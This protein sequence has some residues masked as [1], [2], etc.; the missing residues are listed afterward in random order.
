MTAVL[1]DK[2]L[3]DRVI[4][5]TRRGRYPREYGY[6]WRTSV[7][8]LPRSQRLN[9][10]VYVDESTLQYLVTSKERSGINE[11]KRN[12]TRNAELI[13]YCSCIAVR[14]G[15]VITSRRSR[16]WRAGARQRI[17]SIEFRQRIIF[18]IAF[19]KTKDK[20]WKKRG[21]GKEETKDG[22]HLLVSRVILFYELYLSPF[23]L[24]SSSLFSFLSRHRG[25]TRTRNSD[26]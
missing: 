25:E 12:S 26:P 7:K 20:K 18:L 14:H 17:R 22:Y 11:A 13:H 16:V 2:R 6:S 19:P 21:G 9:Q 3:F 10:D 23:L 24:L 4:S 8:M 15:A 1:L 5:R